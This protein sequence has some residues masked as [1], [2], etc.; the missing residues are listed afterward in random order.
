MHWFFSVLLFLAAPAAFA[1]PW[2]CSE[3]DGSRSFSYDPASATRPNCVHQPIPPT[4]TV[5]RRQPGE[6]Q[7]ARDFPRVD[8]KVQKQR[9]LARREIL[10][11]ELAE[12]KKSLA[13]AMKELAEQQRVS[14]SARADAAADERLRAYRERIRLH[15]TNISNLQKELGG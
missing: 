6:L 15:M 4:N 2:L 7:E 8:A 10:E 14:A 13:A 9:D 11:R 1:E 12:E 5:R 3:P